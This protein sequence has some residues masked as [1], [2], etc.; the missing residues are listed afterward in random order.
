MRSERGF[1]L[2]EVLVAL[3]IAATGIVAVAQTLEGRIN[4]TIA[5]D[6]RTLSNWIAS[7]RFAEIRLARQWPEPGEQRNR[8]VMAG[9]TFFTRETVSSTSDPELRRL[10]I[11]VYSDEERTD[12][13]G[14][15]FGFVTRRDGQ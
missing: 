12:R 6:A 4:R 1:T 10:D 7:N 3:A 2:L 13:S 14:V 9:K 11:L 15:L 8:I 5:L